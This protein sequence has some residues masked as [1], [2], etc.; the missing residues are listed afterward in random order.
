MR[1]RKKKSHDSEN[2][3]NQERWLVSYADFITLLFA[4]FVVMYS[5]SSVNEA[6][7]KSLGAS[8]GSAFSTKKTQTTPTDSDIAAEAEAEAFKNLPEKKNNQPLDKASK[9]EID[10]KRQL[11]EEI[12]KERRQLNKVSELLKETLHVVIEEKLVEVINNDYWISLQMNSE[13]LFLSGDSELSKKAL[14]ILEKITD[15]I[16]E[17]QNAINIEGHTDNIPISNIKFR[18]NWDLS[19]ARASS[20]VMEFEQLGINPTRLSAIGY[21]EFHPVADN[22]TEEGRFKNRRVVLV[23]MSQAFARYGANDEERAKL[24]NLDPTLSVQDNQT[25][26]AN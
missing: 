10:R 20:V 7:Y 9:E 6:K 11:S 8:L 21:G 16:N 5:V 15:V 23:L 26:P 1:S 13:L 19:A 24:L 2:E 17:M 12:L 4:F 14:P 18:S 3:G 22:V 25:I